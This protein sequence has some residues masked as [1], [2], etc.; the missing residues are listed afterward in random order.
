MQFLMHGLDK[1]H[2]QQS[3]KTLRDM[4]FGAIVTGFDEEA[5]ALAAEH[6]LEA[7]VCTHAFTAK[8]SFATD[9]YLAVDVHGQKHVWFN[10]ACPNHPEVQED[11]LR[12]IATWSRNP[13]VAG[14]YVDGARFSSPCSSADFRSFFTCFCQHCAKKAA[15]M[16]FDFGRMRHD[17]RRLLAVFEGR[18]S[19]P[20][21]N[22]LP[23]GGVDLLVF[24]N[25]LPGVW[26]WLRFRAQCVTEHM[27]DAATTLRAA[28]PEALLGMYIFS[29]SIAPWVGQDYGQLRQHVD[30]FAPMIYRS[31]QAG[32][33]PAC[34]NKEVSRL[35]RELV[36][37]DV[38]TDNDAV[39][40]LRTLT[41]FA[42]AADATVAAMDRELP[43]S[44]VQLE[45]QRARNLLGRKHPLVPIIQLDDDALAQSTAAALAGSADGVN[46]F[47]YRADRLPQLQ[48]LI[49][50]HLSEDL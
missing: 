28:H 37:H 43:V 8:D 18:E 17:V 34:L 14:I 32:E 11:H 4:G 2:K 47:A 27:A 21:V 42:L 10:S 25:A 26:D 3:M 5:I 19:L 22:N 20:L 12:R 45:T 23:Y 39:A 1:E 40:F 31:L 30:V 36:I 9:A 41:G 13:G 35:G 6:G 46:F 49:H 29:P 24:F 15:A 7:Y 38:M 50:E 44:A 16:G 48:A 33:G